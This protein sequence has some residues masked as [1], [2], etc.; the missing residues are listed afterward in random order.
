MLCKSQVTITSST[1][2]KNKTF[3]RCSDFSAR[4]WFRQ[5]PG[6]MPLYK[7][8]THTALARLTRLEYIQCIWECA[9][10]ITKQKLY[11]IFNGLK[12]VQLC[13]TQH[14]YL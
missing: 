6:I 9:V 11:N 7:C 1:K 3:E 5:M 14:V 10:F 2:F 12:I 8:P 4:N 13:K